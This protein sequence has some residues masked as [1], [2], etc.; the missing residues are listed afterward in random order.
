MVSISSESF[1]T[2]A[3]RSVAEVW[4]T[5][6]GFGASEG[7]L[8]GGAMV[9]GVARRAVKPWRSER[10]DFAVSVK[11][12]VEARELIAGLIVGVAQGK[13]LAQQYL[14]SRIVLNVD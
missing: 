10:V 7:M 2:C 1:V 14:S 12:S 6:R 13:W 9:M 4:R 5:S 11:A 8:E 3:F